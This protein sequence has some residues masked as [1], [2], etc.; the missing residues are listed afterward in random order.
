MYMVQYWRVLTPIINRTFQKKKM[1]YELFVMSL[2]TLL[3]PGTA[4]LAL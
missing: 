4:K 2:V 1:N 3:V